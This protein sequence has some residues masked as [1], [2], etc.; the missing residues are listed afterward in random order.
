MKIRVGSGNKKIKIDVRRGNK[1]IGLMFKGREN[2]ILLFEFDK[3]GI[4][5]IHSFFVFFSF[6]ALWLDK[7]NNLIDK[8]I[9]KPFELYIRPKKP[10]RKLIEIPFNDKNKKIV[11]FLVGK[12]RFK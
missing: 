1:L 11:D 4:Y 2:D 8:R 7:N 3:E 9:V 10:F 6:L 5:P 12:E